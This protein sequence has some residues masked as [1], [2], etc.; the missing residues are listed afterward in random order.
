MNFADPT[1][2]S[3][4]FMKARDFNDGLFQQDRPA[5]YTTEILHKF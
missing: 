3:R 1:G 5:Q 4:E 2:K